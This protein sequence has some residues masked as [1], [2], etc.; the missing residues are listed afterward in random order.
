M[1]KNSLLFFICL[2][3][4]TAHVFDGCKKE[5]VEEEYEPDR[6]F[7]H[8]PET[9]IPSPVMSTSFTEE[10][11]DYTLTTKDGLL[12]IQVLIPGEMVLLTNVIRIIIVMA[13]LLIQ[14]H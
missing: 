10:F 3:Y 4:L 6:P 11:N 13:L 7:I 14:K 12:I 1:K 8:V 5:K 9:T 2:V